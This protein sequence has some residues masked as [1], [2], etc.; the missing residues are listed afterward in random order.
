MVQR[1]VSGALAGMAATMAMT[2]AM[3]RLHALLD[4]REDYP[5]PP[6]EIIE[7]T[8]SADDEENARADTLAAHFGFGALAGAIFALFPTWKGGGM[9]YGLG[10]WGISYLGWIPAA[11]ILAPAWRHP[12]HRNLLM[13]AVHLVWGATLAKSLRE[14]ELAEEGPFGRHPGKPPNAPASAL[15]KE[16]KGMSR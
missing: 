4:S 12:L 1:I 5:L 3:R 8:G 10:I 6:R 13:I 15:E 2:M 14:M 16:E 7:Q 9:L 11:Q